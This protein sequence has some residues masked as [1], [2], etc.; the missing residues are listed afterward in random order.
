MDNCFPVLN[1]DQYLTNKQLSPT[2]NFICLDLNSLSLEFINK[3]KNDNKTVLVIETS[4]LH[5]MAEQRRLFFEFIEHKIVNPVIIKRDYNNT[6]LDEFR[7]FAST[8]FGALLIDGLGDGVWIGGLDFINSDGDSNDIKSNKL[9]L[10]K[11]SLQKFINRTLFGILQASRVRISKTEYIAC[12]SCGRTL[13]D[14]QETTEF[15]RKRTE[16]LKGVKIAVMGCI[17]NGP[18]EMA[19]ADYGYVGSGVDKIT[20]YREKEIV[21]RNIPANK[22]VDA[23]IEL[24]KEDGIWFEPS[25]RFK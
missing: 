21:K 9:T 6:T 16:H 20:L 4:N 22:A 1:V 18:G 13:F 15:I 25:E 2:L 8:D 10:V 3:I 5:G 23:L 14:L 17:V 12:P 24:I 19:D 11:E 7:L